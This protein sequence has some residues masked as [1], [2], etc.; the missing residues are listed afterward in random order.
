MKHFLTKRNLTIFG[1]GMGGKPQAPPPPVIT[2][3]PA[4]L[5][6]PLLGDTE[7]I[8]SFSY[9]EMID[10]ISDG[11]IEGLINKNGNKVYDDNIFE[12]I[13]LNDAPIKETSNFNSQNISI[14]P[15]R[16]AIKILWSDSEKILK[17]IPSQG[18][19][20]Q[21]FVLQEEIKSGV[22][23][24]PSAV[25][26][27][28]YH[29]DISITEFIK[30]TNAD[31]DLIGTI[32]R[33]FNTS[34]IPEEKP[35]LT[36][37]NIPKM[38]AYLD[39]VKFGEFEDPKFPM[40]LS[41]PNIGNHIYFSISSSS[42]NSFNYFEMPRSFVY[43]A[44][45]TSSGKRTFLKNKLSNFYSTEGSVFYQ[46]EFL[47]VKIFV[48]SIYSTE[49]G[50][51]KTGKI[52]DKYLNNIIVN[53]NEPSLYNYN[54]VQSEFKNGMEF[55]TPFQNFKNINIEVEYNK[56]LVGPFKLLN[57]PAKLT[58]AKIGCGVYRI[59]N[60]CSAESQDFADLTN[61]SS[62]D[63]RYVKNWPVEYNPEGKPALLCDFNFNYATYDK[64]SRNRSSQDA[65]PVTHYITNQNVKEIYLTVNVSALGDTNHIDLV[66]P[67]IGTKPDQT[68]PPYEGAKNYEE[69]ISPEQSSFNQKCTGYLLVVGTRYD[70]GYVVGGGRSILENIFSNVNDIIA[71]ENLYYKSISLIDGFGLLDPDVNSVSKALRP[72]Y[73]LQSTCY[74]YNFTIPN[75]ADPIFT[76]SF[77]INDFLVGANL[78]SK[79]KNL[80]DDNNLFYCF[81]LTEKEKI[82]YQNEASSW[83]KTA[84]FNAKYEPLI[85]IPENASLSL[86]PN[87]QETNFTPIF[88][89]A[90]E[91]SSSLKFQFNSN[92][93][94]FV[95]GYE[96]FT[97]KINN[98]TLRYIVGTKINQFINWR[99]IF[100]NVLTDGSAVDKNY[101]YKIN[102]SN[103][104]NIKK[105]IVDQLW[106]SIPTSISNPLFA[107]TSTGGGLVWSGQTNGTW[108]LLTQ[109]PYSVNYIFNNLPALFAIGFNKD[110]FL[111]RNDI[112]ELD[113]VDNKEYFNLSFLENLIEDYVLKN[114]GSTNILKVENVETINFLSSR[115]L[116]DSISN[117]EN[118]K[119]LGE[120]SVYSVNFSYVK[121]LNKSTFQSGG[122]I[123][124]D[125]LYNNFSIYILYPEVSLLSDAENDIV[126]AYKI[127]S[128]KNNFTANAF[129]SEVKKG[130]S[131]DARQI[132]QAISAGTKLPAVVSFE[133]ETGYE[134]EENVNLI[135]S[136]TFFKYRFDIYGISNGAT[137]L[138]IGR[139]RYTNL[140][141]QKLPSILGKAEEDLVKFNCLKNI[142]VYKTYKVLSGNLSETRYFISDVRIEDNIKAGYTPRVIDYQS[143]VVDSSIYLH[144][145]SKLGTGGIGLSNNSPYLLS[146]NF[147]YN[148]SLI[149]DVVN[150]VK[151][152]LS[153]ASSS[154][155]NLSGGVFT[156]E[157]W[158]NPISISAVNTTRLLMIGANATNSAFTVGFISNGQMTFG[159]PNTGKLNFSTA[160]GVLELNKWQHFAFVFNN[161]SATLYKNGK[162]V[163]TEF[164]RAIPTSNNNVL[165]I[166]YDTTT[167]FAEQ[168]RGYLT[169]LRITKTIVYNGEFA[170]PTSPL[171]TLS[172][173]AQILINAS[174][175]TPTS[176]SAGTTITSGPAFRLNV[177]D[178]F[179]TFFGIERRFF[180]AS[181]NDAT[182]SVV[183][184]YDL[185]NTL[186]LE[187]S[188]EITE[189][190]FNSFV[191]SNKLNLNNSFSFLKETKLLKAYQ[192]P[193]NFEIDSS[194]ID[195]SINS[196]KVDSYRHEFFFPPN[197]AS[198]NFVQTDIFSYNFEVYE[199]FK[200]NSKLLQERL[201]V[202]SSAQN[203]HFVVYFEY[204]HG[205]TKNLRNFFKI[206]GIS[207]LEIEIFR[208][209]EPEQRYKRN[210]TYWNKNHNLTIY[211]RQVDS[212]FTD[213]TVNDI[214]PSVAGYSKTY[215][216]DIFK[217]Y[218]GD[219][220]NIS[221]SFIETFT[222]D[223]SKNRTD[224][225]TFTSTDTNSKY[226]YPNL[227]L[228][229]QKDKIIE[230]FNRTREPYSKVIPNVDS[231][232]NAIKDISVTSSVSKFDVGFG[233]IF[234]ELFGLASER[235]YNAFK[236]SIFT[237]PFEDIS[238]YTK[239]PANEAFIPIS[240]WTLYNKNTQKV[241][242]IFNSFTKEN[243]YSDLSNRSELEHIELTQF[244]QG[245]T[246]NYKLY[247]NR[248]INSFYV[249]N[250]TITDPISSL[251][252]KYSEKFSY[253]KNAGVFVRWS[254]GRGAHNIVFQK[255][256]FPDGFIMGDFPR[257]TLQY[258]AP[259]W[260]FHTNTNTER[261][262]IYGGTLL[263][264]SNYNMYALNFKD[265]FEGSSSINSS[266][267]LK[268]LSRIK[269]E[270]ERVVDVAIS[271]LKDRNS[272]GSSA[273][274]NDFFALNAEESPKLKVIWKS[275]EN[276]KAMYTA[277]YRGMGSDFK[278]YKT[279]EGLKPEPLPEE[280]LEISYYE[281]NI[282][283]KPISSLASYANYSND[284]GTQIII[285]PPKQKENGETV[286]RYVKV[287]RLSHETLSPLIQ[288]TI[289]LQKVTEIIPQNF[290]Y[291]F[292][293]MVG[294][295]IDSRAFSQLP[296][297]MFHCKLK[298]VLV[299][300]NYFI[301]DPET[302]LDVRYMREKIGTKIYEDIWDGSF[303]LAWTNNPAWIMMDLLINKRYGL[304]NHIESEQIDVWELYKIAKWCDGADENGNFQGVSDGYG[305]IEPRHTFNGVIEEKYN[306]F[307]IVN[308]VA[309][310]FRGN[311][312]YM[313]S[314]ITFDDDRPKPPAGE[315]TN[316]DV[317][318]GI[319]NYTNMRKDE[320]FTALD[321]AFVDERNDYKPSIEYVE[322]SD[323]IRKRGI[324]K[325]N[326]NAFGI[327]SRGQAK[328]F[329]K[330]ILHHTAKE[331]LNVSFITD[332][333]ALMFRPGDI[334]QI[335]DE[336]LSTYKNYGKILEVEDVNENLFKIK[337]DQ[338]INSGIYD[339]NEISLHT[340][341]IKPKR[342][343]ILNFYTEKI[344]S[345]SINETSL[346]RNFIFSHL[347]GH[348]N[349]AP[350]T[351]SYI[352]R[353]YGSF[354]AFKTE[355]YTTAGLDFD[356]LN[357]IILNLNIF[358]NGIGFENI[359]LG[360]Y[361]EI[362][363]FSLARNQDFSDEF[364][365][366]TGILEF[367]FKSVKFDSTIPLNPSGPSGIYYKSFIIKSGI[368]VYLSSIDEKSSLK[369]NL[370][371]FWQMSFPQT[372]ISGY[373]N[374]DSTNAYSRINCGINFLEEVNYI[375]SNQNLENQIFQK[376]YIYPQPANVGKVNFCYQKFDNKIINYSDIIESDKPTVET[377]FIHSYQTGSYKVSGTLANDSGEIPTEYSE[378]ILNK[379]GEQGLK[380]ESVLFNLDSIPVGSAYSLNLIG[381]EKFIF[382]INS[383]NEN[384]INEYSI[385]A[386]QYSESKFSEIEEPIQYDKIED[387]FNQLYYYSRSSASYDPEKTLESPI[388]TNVSRFNKSNN[389]GFGLVIE[390]QMK[391][392]LLNQIK[393]KVYIKTPSK[394][395]RNIEI[396]SDISAYNKDTNL[397]TLYWNGSQNG[398]D[399]LGTYTVYIMATL[400]DGELYKFSVENSRSVTILDY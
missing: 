167:G 31:T 79:L 310:V 396:S 369:A 226:Y 384:Y 361:L 300:S 268:I 364:P 288:K 399:E 40:T 2:L 38:I 349:I 26:I 254:S 146:E 342:N 96:Y 285:P 163:L 287:T 176:I 212:S 362:P 28:S 158:I 394:Q 367:N 149:F 240:F 32:E 234:Y 128:S 112:W 333:K 192:F 183:K 4:V 276:P 78:E 198:L 309:S 347:T 348:Y 266:K 190:Q 391:H 383:I 294:T 131:A 346:F 222:L 98:L 123:G 65:V 77:K 93:T 308:Q 101:S 330:H 357:A 170:V 284:L 175:I 205:L 335:H 365:V 339:S 387:T 10:L 34:P 232:I 275:K 55:Q 33:A 9:A 267:K 154:S 363:A 336:L 237:V 132:K 41:I 343:E 74:L 305:G 245:F 326:I 52:L 366:Y 29:P 187:S 273:L 279:R 311:V 398:A 313:N 215:F 218:D 320:E 370:T 382:K 180:R 236:T 323:S 299:P 255:V 389:Q 225:F 87:S 122:I 298:K 220:P 76:P 56:E 246:H 337:I 230:F 91:A 73:N 164:G 102:L 196:L 147:I 94:L 290:S 329:G 359:G 95:V 249:N 235:N 233:S 371:G 224:L 216:D 126:I 277:S 117:Y 282:T 185:Q 44:V 111:Q 20:S 5:T 141:T 208:Y 137:L 157:F 338:A 113:P 134:K 341:V 227:D 334:I 153:I 397:F 304:G 272:L 150:T 239:Q 312:Y 53:Q 201:S 138:D 17:S 22:K 316:A 63:I 376:E 301:E 85:T 231:L 135:S 159:V 168:F 353:T 392:Y 270:N 97:E 35:F 92:E 302:G 124:Y 116:Q 195:S 344:E 81:G 306:I 105:Y 207:V 130:G 129:R 314:M 165:N 345:I 84:P 82:I 373:I 380:K 148:G 59:K 8:T 219:S 204:S 274:E 248:D 142:Y 72:K 256:D 178:S 193:I 1:A 209:W 13:Y 51:K 200:T 280:F 140:K 186:I 322:D 118:G 262:P 241:S 19:I 194:S 12:G 293:A 291:P 181:N 318:D 104:P 188:Y 238:T 57:T 213:E 171:D 253:G 378:I 271:L 16:N 49:Y 199:I 109:S 292:S 155:F 136:D 89:I 69:L 257:R 340:P 211:I 21:T 258:D 151:S 278:G 174:V 247:V 61:E 30:Q 60:I 37:V 355:K 107:E 393:Y 321:I 182:S 319:F 189:S 106:I 110:Y 152:R 328:R 27:E 66:A 173:N 202:S 395:T 23:Q 83:T 228:S 36:V 71:G 46:Y 54:L 325:R 50:I 15:I 386:T 283:N 350:N 133:V 368:N 250:K 88:P 295:K 269:N 160:T 356:T 39:V 70:N 177:T 210:S 42:L 3:Y 317:K 223:A 156:I 64:F 179:G 327:T 263:Y 48:W 375:V 143:P 379:T 243:N 351:S 139:K 62:D 358:K 161:G 90:Q 100:N 315:F 125:N 121:N 86:I 14:I 372:C 80:R 252:N 324:L 265:N 7:Q 169:D 261:D 260:F 214:F 377:F 286:R 119:L 6:P 25:T 99:A 45:K 172:G 144:T 264:T 11:P 18:K 47:N 388:I 120:S 360:S 67:G 162:S 184:A 108:N 43:N 75:Y 296:T 289:N 221:K 229:P 251:S 244:L 58:D 217:L 103:Y 297:R 259:T 191:N 352:T 197:T 303:K 381:K 114:N 400:Q 385:M 115:A 307:E 145:I 68:N 127:Y 242:I 203:P 206:K 331:K 332:I 390:W 374:F 24:F 166:G 281:I 354:P